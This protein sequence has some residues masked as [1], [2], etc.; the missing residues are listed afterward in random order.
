MR[1]AGRPRIG[2]KSFANT[3]SGSGGASWR[4]S[5]PL[6]VV[7]AANKVTPAD[8]PPV[9]T[10]LEMAELLRIHPT[11][12]YRMIKRGEIPSFR[13]GSEHRFNREV[14]DAWVSTHIASRYTLSSA[15]AASDSRL[16]C[17]PILEALAPWP[18]RDRTTIE[19]VQNGEMNSA[20]M[21][22]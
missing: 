21:T 5:T 7:M 22:A 17:Q 3:G 1:Y 18:G 11:I 2:V 15:W 10:L 8:P 13:V 19:F 14:I 12:L 4:S 6:A 16:A 20:F 9:L